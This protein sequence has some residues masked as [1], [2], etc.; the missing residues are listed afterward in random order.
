MTRRMSAGG[1]DFGLEVPFDAGR[2]FAAFGD[3]PDNERGAA[4]GVARREYTV[5]LVM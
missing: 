3:G 2:G 1:D 5:T 4:F